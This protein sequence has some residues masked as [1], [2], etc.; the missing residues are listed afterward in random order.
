MIRHVKDLEERIAQHI[1]LANF[2]AQNSALNLGLLP[3]TEL[4]HLCNWSIGNQLLSWNEWRVWDVLRESNLVK[5]LSEIYFRFSIWKIE[6]SSWRCNFSGRHLLFFLNEWRHRV[7]IWTLRILHP[8]VLNFLSFVREKL[9]L[10]WWSRWRFIT[11]HWP[12]SSSKRRLEHLKRCLKLLI[13][14]HE[15]S[16]IKLPLQVCRI[17]CLELFKILRNMLVIKDPI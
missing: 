17:N 10:T 12:S 13:L 5:F 14:V 15:V 11:L 6:G 2:L 4:H 8:R 7:L 16:L 9:S 1:V 3:I